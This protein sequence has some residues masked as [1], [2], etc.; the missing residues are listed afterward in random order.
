METVRIVLS[1]AE[2]VAFLIVL[3]IAAIMFV[4][5]ERPRPP[6]DTCEHLIIKRK[7]KTRFG[8]RYF[9]TVR[10]GFETPPEYCRNYL[11]R[12]DGGQDDV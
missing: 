5:K 12:K 3:S 7:R 1:F 9:C 10:Q 8:P 11:Q 2:A 4:K 6:C